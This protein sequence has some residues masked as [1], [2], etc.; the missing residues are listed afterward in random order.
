MKPS[1]TFQARTIP[2][3]LRKNRLLSSVTGPV[4]GDDFFS[5]IDA[6]HL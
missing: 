1:K 6:V 2:E 3:A 4:T 5:D